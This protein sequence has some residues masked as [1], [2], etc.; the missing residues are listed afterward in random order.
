MKPAE[1]RVLALAA[2]FGRIAYV[3][4]INGVPVD[5][6]LSCKGAKSGRN[7]AAVTGEWLAKFDPDVVIIEDAKTVRYKKAKTKS[8][9]RSMETVAKRSPAMVV[10][11]QRVQHFDNKFDEAQAWV[12]AFPKL[13]PKQPKRRRLWDPEPR[14]LVF[15]EALALAEENGFAGNKTYRKA[16][17]AEDA[18]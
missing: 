5:W 14:N 10:T 18:K 8:L 7:A 13:A 9:L 1:A 15:F 17:A 6:A 11:T 12:T 2:R 3:Y 4:L 16:K